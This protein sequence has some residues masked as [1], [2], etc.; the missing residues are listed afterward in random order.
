MIEKACRVVRRRL[1]SLVRVE[2]VEPREAERAVSAEFKLREPF[3]KICRYGGIKSEEALLVIAPATR[4]L[5]KIPYF[6]E[7]YLQLVP[8]GKAVVVMQNNMLGDTCP[9]F[10]VGRGL[11]VQLALKVVERL[12]EAEYDL[13]PRSS[14]GGNYPVSLGKIIRL[15]GVL[16]C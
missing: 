11:Y 14:Y 7:F 5:G 12:S 4:K 16:V 15:P 9:L 10:K 2:S 6:P 13:R 1:I 8:L 3:F